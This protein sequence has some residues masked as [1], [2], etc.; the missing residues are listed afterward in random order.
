MI[1]AAN[2]IRFIGSLFIKYEKKLEING[3]VLKTTT[4]WVKGIN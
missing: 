1:I 2:S 3:N 4:A